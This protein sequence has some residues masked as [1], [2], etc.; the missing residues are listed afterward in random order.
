[1]ILVVAIIMVLAAISIPSMIA[2]RIAA[3]EAGAVASIR[4]INTAQTG[5]SINY[6]QFGYSDNL[7]KLSDPPPGQAVSSAHGGF[8]DWV[9]GCAKQPCSRTGYQFAITNPIGAP[10]VITQYSVVA[11][12]ALREQ[13]GRRGFCGS[14]LTT[15]KFDPNGGTTCTLYLQ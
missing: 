14:D 2:S 11:T 3:N 5:Y 4:S 6:P 12:P 10:G 1:L 7:L 9:L 8:L 15:I 13:T